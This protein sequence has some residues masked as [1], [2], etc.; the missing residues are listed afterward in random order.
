MG[1]GTLYKTVVGKHSSF[2]NDCLLVLF[3]VYTAT[4]K[5]TRGKHSQPVPIKREQQSEK[6]TSICNSMCVCVCVCIC[7]CSA[8]IL[9][10]KLRCGRAWSVKRDSSR[11]TDKIQ[12]QEEDYISNNTTKALH[13]VLDAECTGT[14]PIALWMNWHMVKLP[15]RRMGKKKILNGEIIKSSKTGVR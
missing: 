13:S 12:P 1:S 8:W 11:R 6:H 5:Y 3:T 10:T 2:A 4:C 9:F 7:I 15:D 14:S